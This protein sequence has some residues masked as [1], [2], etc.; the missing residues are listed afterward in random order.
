MKGLARES[1][2]VRRESLWQ[3]VTTNSISILSSSVRVSAAVCLRIDWWRRAIVLRSWKWAGAG[4]LPPCL[5]PVGRSIAISGVPSW[6]CA[7]AVLPA[8][9]H[10][11]W[12]RGGWRIN[13]LRQH[14][15]SSSRESVGR[16]V[17]D[18]IG[19]LENRNAS[20]LRNRRADARCDGEQNPRTGRPSAEESCGSRGLGAYFLLYQGGYLPAC[21]GRARQSDLS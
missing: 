4:R 8:R 14:L 1:Q 19:R 9:N 18:G 12:L 13:N 20:V 17:L 2:C 7:D 16:R 11:S 15:A 3:R 5:V 21:A 6:V 10:L